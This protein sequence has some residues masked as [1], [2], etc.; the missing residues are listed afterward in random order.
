MTRVDA[1][2]GPG[3]A[4]A[5]PTVDAACFLCGAGD[6]DPVWT[7]PDRAFGV[8]IAGSMLGGLAENTSMLLG[9]Q[10]LLLVAIAFYGV[11]ALL[12]GGADQGKWAKG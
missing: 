4:A 9:F 5:P 11:S 2:G 1:P 12:G 7:T 3:G 8:N 6:A 10:Y